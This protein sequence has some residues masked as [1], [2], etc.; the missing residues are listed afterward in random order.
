[1][2]DREAPSVITPADLLRTALQ[3]PVWSRTTE[4]LNLNLLRF[5][6]GEGVGLHVNAEVD[7]FGV[8]LEGRGQITI[9][10]DI[11]IVEAGQVFV[12]PRG[13]TRAFRALSSVFAYVSCHQRR[14]GLMPRFPAG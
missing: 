10:D 11:Q 14:A 13:A 8:V 12:I 6:A 5:E 3:G 4:Q 1:M 2:S 9:G 7:V